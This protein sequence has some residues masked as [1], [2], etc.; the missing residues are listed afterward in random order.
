MYSLVILKS[1]SRKLFQSYQN[2]EDSAAKT[3]ER[4]IWSRIVSD[5]LLQILR[6]RMTLVPSGLIH[7]HA[8]C[9]KMILILKDPS[10]PTL[11]QTRKKKAAQLME[12]NPPSRKQS[13]SSL[14]ITRPYFSVPGEVDKPRHNS[15]FKNAGAF[16]KA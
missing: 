11:P 6:Y 7:S 4:W 15:Q 1:N 16:K 12:R 8:L 3:Q 13:V 9:W 2:T 14:A 10:M 5:V